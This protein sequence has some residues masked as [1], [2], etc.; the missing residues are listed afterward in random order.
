MQELKL[1]SRKSRTSANSDTIVLWDSVTLT[2]SISV[3][4]SPAYRSYR[5]FPGTSTHNNGHN[6]LA[7][8]FAVAL[9][10]SATLLWIRRS[11]DILI[12]Q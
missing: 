3:L 4:V 10:L 6:T 12:G 11:S 8:S 1:K 9:V 5:S 2:L 7:F